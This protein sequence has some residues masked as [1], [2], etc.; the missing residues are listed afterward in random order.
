MPRVDSLAPNPSLHAKL[1]YSTA[2][3]SADDLTRLRAE[4]VD[5]LRT[6]HSDPAHVRTVELVVSELATNALSYAAPPYR[7]VIEQDA[8][9]E[10]IVAVSDA[11]NGVASARVPSLE[12]GGYGLNLVNVLAGVWGVRRDPTTRRK[13]VWAAISQP[14]RSGRLSSD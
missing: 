5:A 11:G 6:M 10:T 9:G 7:V 12:H 13:T 14:S 3:A 1:T 2:F 4:C 8:A